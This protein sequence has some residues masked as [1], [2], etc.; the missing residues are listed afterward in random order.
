MSFADRLKKGQIGERIVDEWLISKGFVPY[1]PIAGAAHPFDRL[2]ASRDKRKILVVEVKSKPAREKY[3][4]QGIETR[5]YEDYK[6]ISEK[7]GIRIFIAFVDE[8]AARIYGSFLDEL[9]KPQGRYPLKYPDRVYFSP[10]HMRDIAQLTREQCAELRALRVS[11]Y[12]S[13]AGSG[14]GR[15]AP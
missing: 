13:G 11:N 9:E 5:H 10:K 2:V 8:D 14:A 6:H 1:R 15:T 4:D 12:K 3:G 7:Y